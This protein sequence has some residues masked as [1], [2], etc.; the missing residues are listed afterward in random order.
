MYGWLLLRKS[1]VTCT[2]GARAG[3]M[4]LQGYAR[5]AAN[6]WQS[7]GRYNASQL[8]VPLSEMLDTLQV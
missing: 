3:T 5:G 7:F 2:V 1:V 6:L 8:Q 4:I